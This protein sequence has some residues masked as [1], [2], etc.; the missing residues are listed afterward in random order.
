MKWLGF[1]LYCIV[2]SGSSL[3]ELLSSIPI[4]SFLDYGVLDVPKVVAGSGYDF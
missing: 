1:L 4:D 3:N 2:S